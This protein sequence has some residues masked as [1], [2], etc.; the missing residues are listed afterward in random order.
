M[1]TTE[2]LTLN[3]GLSGSP[4]SATAAAH[5]TTPDGDPETY[6]ARVVIAH[7]YLTQRGGA[8][9]VVLAMARAF[10]GSPIVTSLYEPDLTFPDFSAYEVRTSRLQHVSLL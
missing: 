8:E 6:G 1:T 5:S 7:D 10:P 9:R 4:R 3:S 2:T